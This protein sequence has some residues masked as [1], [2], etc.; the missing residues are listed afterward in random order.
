MR[1]K[2]LKNSGLIIC[3][4]VLIN[5]LFNF[6][7]KDVDVS[8]NYFELVSSLILFLFFYFF[9]C[10]F[11]NSTDEKY[12]ISTGIITY[13]ISFYLFENIILFFSQNITIGTTFIIVNL[14]WLIFFVLF[15]KKRFYIFLIFLLFFIL[16]K[17]NSVYSEKFEINKNIQGD[18]N[19]VF[20]PNTE[21]IFNESLFISISEPLMK[22]YP[23]FMSYIDALLYRIAF[24]ISQYNFMIQNSFVFLWLFI[25][26]FSELDL[27]KRNR[28]FAVTF[29]LSLTINSSWLEFLFFS[30]LMSERIA[31]YLFLGLL[32]NFIRNYNN[33]KTYIFSLTL[34]SF[35]YLT[36]QFFSLLLLLIFLYCIFNKKTRKHSL[37]LLFAY[38]LRE[39]S[40]L[41][42]FKGVPKDHHISQIDLFDTALDLLLLRELRLENINLILQN[43]FID[44]PSTYLILLFLF[45]SFFYLIISN[46]LK[47]VNTCLITISFLNVIFVFLLYIS[48]WQNMEL[49]SPIR[50]F[51]SFIPIYITSIFYNLEFFTKFY[52]NK[53]Q[54]IKLQ[55]NQ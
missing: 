48:V 6:F 28:I 19:D 44:K 38:L 50:Y 37:F 20:L 26:L 47:S 1:K 11:K 17:F 52:I 41:N 32:A 12:T 43:L 31:S 49:E 45:S 8:I 42:Q 53:T 29:F 14:I 27:N 46:D 7:N 36:K 30:S 21:K 55:Q 34:L 23:Q 51:Y 4:P 10:A 3:T 18:V 35:I 33:S 16:N 9:G 13:W 15:L 40:H 24:D 5:F 25:L 39:A 2:I 54:F 22:G